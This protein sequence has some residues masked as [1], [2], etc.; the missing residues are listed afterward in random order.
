MEQSDKITELEESGNTSIKNISKYFSEL[1]RTNFFTNF[2]GWFTCICTVTALRRSRKKCQ[3][4]RKQERRFLESV[5]S[6]CKGMMRLKKAFYFILYFL[7]FFGTI[8]K[9]GF[10]WLFCFCSFR[11]LYWAIPKILRKYLDFYCFTVM[12]T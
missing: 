5:I 4:L 6:N 11:S 8:L 2:F 9:N 3:T 10:F 12:V 1:F 7:A